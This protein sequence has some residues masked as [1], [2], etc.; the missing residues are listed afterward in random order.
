MEKIVRKLRLGEES[1]KDDLAY[2]LGRP[3]EERIEAMEILRRE[4]FGDTAGLQRTARVVQR[5][6]D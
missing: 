1:P 6:K 5:Q 2:W 3:P 4:W